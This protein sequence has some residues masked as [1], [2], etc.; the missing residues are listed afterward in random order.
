MRTQAIRRTI[1]IAGLTVLCSCRGGCGRGGDVDR[2][3][4]V[5]GR[6]AMF[7]AAA[8]IVAGIDVGQLR[9]SPSAAKIQALAVESQADERTLAEVQRRTGFAPMQQPVAP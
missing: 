8:R 9:A 7:P 1:F 2:A 4:T 6:L 3:L 5:Q